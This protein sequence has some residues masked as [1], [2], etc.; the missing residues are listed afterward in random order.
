MFFPSACLDFC[1]FSPLFAWFIVSTDRFAKC[2]LLGRFLI[3]RSIFVFDCCFFVLEG[4]ET[5]KTIVEYGY[6][7]MKGAGSKILVVSCRDL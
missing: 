5:P 4:L 2:T 1:W 6:R 3:T 7:L